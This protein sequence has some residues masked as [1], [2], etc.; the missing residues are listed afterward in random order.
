MLD[1]AS[2]AND[3]DLISDLTAIPT[4]RLP[5]AHRT[6]AAGPE[7]RRGGRTAAPGS[8][9]AELYTAFAQLLLENEE[10]D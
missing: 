3:P 1:P 5:A 8:E 9:E 10:L 2:T 7:R 4:R 6:P